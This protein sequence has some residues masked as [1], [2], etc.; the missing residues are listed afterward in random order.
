MTPVLI[1]FDAEM[2]SITDMDG[3]Y[4]AEGF[5]DAESLLEYCDDNDLE[6]TNLDDLHN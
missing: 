6:P 5:T 3:S 2:Y 1:S 4:I